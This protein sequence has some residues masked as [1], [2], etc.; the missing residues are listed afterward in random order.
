MAVTGSHVHPGIPHRILGHT[1]LDLVEVPGH[2]GWGL[3][4]EDG[5]G[6]VLERQVNAG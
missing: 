6:I 5:K 2:E 3:F 1:R 4:V